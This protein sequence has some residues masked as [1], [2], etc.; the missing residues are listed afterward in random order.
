MQTAVA[1]D[2]QNQK[3]LGTFWVDS[4]LCDYLPC[5]RMVGVGKYCLLTGE[6]LSILLKWIA[7]KKKGNTKIAFTE[8]SEHLTPTT[9]VLVA[10]KRI[11]SF[12]C[13]A[14][15]VQ[16]YILQKHVQEEQQHVV[17]LFEKDLPVL[18]EVL[19]NL[20]AVPAHWDAPCTVTEFWRSRSS[21]VKLI[22]SLLKDCK[23]FHM[24]KSIEGSL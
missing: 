14:P 18:H 6:H 16:R 21:K 22:C 13:P 5:Y 19:A 24:T 12:L 3:P 15:S 10:Q 11:R 20:F 17:L 7:K 8:K 9:H 23:H 4:E 1:Q 2:T